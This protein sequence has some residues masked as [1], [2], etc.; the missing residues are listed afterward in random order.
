MLVSAACAVYLPR[1]KILIE[2]D[3]FHIR[4]Q[5]NPLRPLPVATEVNLIDNLKRLDL[6]AR[7]RSGAHPDFYR[8]YH[9]DQIA[10]VVKRIA[11]NA[12]RVSTFAF[13]A[14]GPRL[15]ELFDGSEQLVGVT[16][17]PAY[18]RTIYLPE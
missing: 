11:T 13:R 9:L 14:T 7:P 12:N 1:E 17:T 4:P 15:G 8:I 2:G 18:S 10:D 5:T 16:S 3:P 6:D